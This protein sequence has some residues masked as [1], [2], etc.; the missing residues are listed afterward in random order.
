MARLSDQIR[1][2][3]VMELAVFRSPSEVAKLVEKEFGISISRQQVHEYNPL[4]S[5]GHDVAKKWTVLFEA[6]RERFLD[7]V[8]D[9]PIVHRAYRLRRL[10]DM[11]L[12]AKSMGNLR[13]A[14]ALLEQ[15]AKEV[16]G[17]Y[18]NSR[19]LTGRIDLPSREQNVSELTDEEIDA[20]I[21][22]LIGEASTSCAA[23]G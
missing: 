17:C 19:K 2:F 6:T 15:A 14:A 1:R 11:F 18:T 12:K 7:E 10:D 20:R 5:K 8:A 16:G 23:S 3:I 9:I 21:A 22:E 4:G 13:L